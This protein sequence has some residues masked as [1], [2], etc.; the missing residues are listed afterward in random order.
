MGFG[1]Q[2]P[3]AFEL[4]S[5]VLYGKHRYYA[6]DELDGTRDDEQLYR[7]CAWLNPSKVN[8]YG[9]LPVTANYL[10][11]FPARHGQSGYN[12]CYFAASHARDAL[13][14]YQDKA[15]VSPACIVLEGIL[16]P[17]PRSVWSTLQSSPG[18]TSTF[19]LGKRGILF[20]DPSRQKQNYIL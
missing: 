4:V 9:A 17:L 18:C 6:F 1:V 19:D 7:I 5:D 8:A 15:V 10:N 13:R 11:R 20:F 14:I 2:S 16:D 12:F 3:W